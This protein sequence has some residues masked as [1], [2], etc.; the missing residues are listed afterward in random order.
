MLFSWCPWHLRFLQS[1]LPLL[2]YYLSIFLL[3]RKNTISQSP[4]VYFKITQNT[5]KL[6]SRKWLL[7]PAHQIAFEFPK[8]RFQSRH[9]RYWFHWNSSLWTLTLQKEAVSWQEALERAQTCL[10]LCC[11][12]SW[13]PNTL[14]LSAPPPHLP[15]SFQHALGFSKQ[16]KAGSFW[17]QP[18][19]PSWSQVTPI[20]IIMCAYS[21]HFICQGWVFCFSRIVNL[22]ISKR[23]LWLYIL[24]TL[25]N[26]IS[27]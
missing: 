18:S 9:R 22:K 16:H 19:S 4:E 14:H 1:F 23:W 6:S 26:R 15:P 12:V 3:P 7:F 25:I 20:L 27:F 5:Y 13:I 17:S 21:T 11:L 24:K 10:V 8:L 2:K